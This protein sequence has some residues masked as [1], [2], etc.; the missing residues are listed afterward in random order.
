MRQYGDKVV[1][2]F[3]SRISRSVSRSRC[4]Q[5][6]LGR[7]SLLPLLV[8]S[9]I[10]PK[11]AYA[12]DVLARDENGVEIVSQKFSTLDPINSISIGPSL[13]YDHVI[14]SNIGS[15]MPPIFSD[16]LYDGGT[17]IDLLKDGP[18]IIGGDL[19]HFNYSSVTARY[20]SNAGDKSYIVKQGSDKYIYYKVDGS[21]VTYNGYHGA[22]SSGAGFAKIIKIENPDK[23]LVTV[24]HR[25]SVF[26]GTAG[27]LTYSAYPIGPQ[28]ISTNDGYMLQFEYAMP[29]SAL[30]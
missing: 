7:P 17:Y 30:G 10:C 9:A 25:L 23:S 29:E 16:A 14:S 1:S 13:S 11:F 20:E 24:S 4:M 28:T 12:Q 19:K 26:S 8:A 5:A 3:D 2:K 15:L 6:L 18:Y 22:N 27:G 21:I